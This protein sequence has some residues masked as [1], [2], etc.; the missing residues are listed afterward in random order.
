MEDNQD[1]EWTQPAIGFNLV[2]FVVTKFMLEVLA[3]SSPIPAGVFT[4]TF[5]LGAG[6]G[7]LYGYILRL[8]IGN[9]INEAAY[10]IIGA[11]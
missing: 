10:A 5:I 1:T 6:F 4:P 9:S 7:R 8:I 11:A 3:I 2:V